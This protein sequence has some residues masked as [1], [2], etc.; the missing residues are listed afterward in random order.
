MDASIRSAFQRK[1]EH[2]DAGGADLSFVLNAVCRHAAAGPL[3]QYEQQLL[4]SPGAAV[5]LGRR[6]NARALLRPAA[7]CAANSFGATVLA[8]SN[9]RHAA[10]RHR[11]PRR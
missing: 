6:A 10:A 3:M 5:A 1:V 4:Q 8:A 7:P 11:A 9:R 2:L